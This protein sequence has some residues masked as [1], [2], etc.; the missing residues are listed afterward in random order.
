MAIIQIQNTFTLGELD[1]RLLARVNF[2]GYY[3]GGRK[4]RN[5]VVIPQGGI[6]Q[7]PGTYFTDIATNRTSGFYITDETQVLFLV[8]SYSSEKSYLIVVRP[9]GAGVPGP[10]DNVAIDIYL[11]G[12]LVATLQNGDGVPW[13]VSQIDDMRYIRDDDRVLLLHHDTRPYQ[14]VRGAN[15]ATWTIS[16]QPIVFFPTFDFSYKDGGTAIYTGSTVTFTP[17]GT[18]GAGITV[19]CA[20][21][22]PFTSNHYGGLFIGNGGVLRITDVSST[23]VITGYT[24]E[25][26]A[27]AAAIRGDL[28]L[29]KEPA[30]GDGG[31]GSNPSG[32]IGT[33]VA[34]GWPKVGT[35]FQNRLWYANTPYLK[36][37]MTA[38]STFVFNNFDD[39]EP[40]DDNAF[41]YRVGSDS[42]N[43]INHLIGSNALIALTTNSMF[44]TYALSENPVTPGNMFM[45]EQNREGSNEVLAQLIDDQILYVDYHGNV[46]KSVGFDII[47]SRF[48]TADASL[49]SP[50]LIRNPREAAVYEN[51][52]VSQGNFYFLCNRDDGSLATFQTLK[53][54]DI[55]AWTLSTT[56]GEYLDICSNRDQCYVLVKRQTP[57]QSTIG[58]NQAVLKANS[59]MSR[60]FNIT[61]EC[62]DAGN[63][64]ELFDSLDV[65]DDYVIFGNSSPFEN[66]IFYFNTP[67]GASIEPVFEYLDD[68]NNW[69]VFSPTDTT[70]GFANDGDISFIMNDLYGWSPQTVN[71]IERK[72]WIRIQRTAEN[73]V[74]LPIEDIIIITNQ[75]AIFIERLRFD[76]IVDC[77]TA[78]T[79]DAN[80]DITGLT[81]LAS[82]QVWA[83]ELTANTYG[84]NA[85]IPHGPYIVE[86]TGALSLGEDLASKN[87]VIGMD[88][89]P[90]IV[91]MPLVAQLE[92]GINVYLPKLVQVVFVDYYESAG[93]Y[94]AGREIC[95]LKI[96]SPALDIPLELK[97]SFNEI[98][99]WK[100]RDPRI[101]IPITR[102]QPLP[103]TIIGLGYKVTY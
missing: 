9:D 31:A 59:D 1:P 74:T 97:T 51:S 78:A 64:V 60:F 86:S 21:A 43:E 73:I 69:V 28:S 41:G 4:L 103:F 100:G 7:K 24:I 36:N 48:E 87:F 16:A 92:I 75:E 68:N 47:Q 70:N 25:D 10:T 35:I 11:N 72:F 53:G 20:N 58:Y 44:S 77:A 17:S 91:P 63:D 3:K 101:E 81:G 96:G 49:L 95:P 19:T 38:S 34:R 79:T 12:T 88:A 89:P 102:T 54:Q 30:F 99:P 15:D 39:S 46:V 50:H 55:N 27:A 93:L 32:L 13:E 80:G 65:K 57:Y 45:T 85:G 56:Q 76:Y 33:A 23:T 22:T 6:K 94:L 61:T 29:L 2:E 98:P 40:D 37:F 18:T 83:L 14:L 82:Q 5:C 90:E 66:I 52:A 71:N 84:V 67:A 26:F 62:A 8:Y 42:L